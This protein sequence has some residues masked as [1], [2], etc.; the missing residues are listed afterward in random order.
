MNNQ[1]IL[2]KNLNIYPSKVEAG[3]AAGIAIEKKITELQ[4]IQEEVRIIFAAAPSQNETLEYLTKSKLIDW[5]KINAF[6][7][8]EYLGLPP[9]SNQL[10]SN[11]L[12]E[13]LFSKV[14]I[15]AINVINTLGD[16][17]EEMDSYKNKL[18][19][20]DIDIVCLGIG[21]NGHIAFNDPP[22]ADF[23]DSQVIKIV[24]LD[25]L[26][27]QQQVNDECFETIGK[28][29]KEAV[30]LTI[31]ALMKGRYIYCIVTG[32]NKANAVKCTLSGPID[33]CCP[34]SVL[35]THPHC[36]FYL[37]NAAVS[38]TDL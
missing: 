20:K 30:T 5:S 16:V 38:K 23:K 36:K 8:D 32:S 27:R 37:D 10:F 11:Y 33:E 26:C 14:K 17:I 34:A 15:G 13:K 35:R 24:K 19:E 18:M 1:K 31:P 2:N 9:D 25:E 6:N 28:V 7:M 29:P 4:E 22:V 21:E 12:N 3:N